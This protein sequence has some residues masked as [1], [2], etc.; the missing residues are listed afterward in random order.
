MGPDLARLRKMHDVFFFVAR[1]GN[2]SIAGRQR[3]SDGMHARHHAGAFVDFVDHRCSDARH[4]AHVDHHVGRIRELYA[5]LRQRRSH[6][7][8][9]KWQNVHGAATHGTFEKRAQLFA[10]FKRVFPIVG[11]SGKVFRVRTD[12]G[13][14]LHARDIA[15]VGTRV[16]AS[17]PKFFV[18][19]DERTALH[20]FRADGVVF[21]LRAVHPMDSRGLRELRHF[22]HPAEQV[23]VFAQGNGGI[24]L[25]RRA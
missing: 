13:A 7:P 2:V 5:D 14:A 16:I 19:L 25:F 1:P 9:A 3:R 10:H 20:H 11:G 8:H 12:K 22:L 23:I 6:R 18:Q 21:L 15:G 24:S 4:D 17:G